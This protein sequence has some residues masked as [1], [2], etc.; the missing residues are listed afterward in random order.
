MM[1]LRVHEQLWT[2]TLTGLSSCM[3]CACV[4][5]C[6]SVDACMHVHMCVCILLL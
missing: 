3:V 5:L 1:L 2:S 4:H 6:A